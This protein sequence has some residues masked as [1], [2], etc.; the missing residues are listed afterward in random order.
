MAEMRLPGYGGEQYDCPLCGAPVTMPRSE[1]RHIDDGAV[2]AITV[3]VTDPGTAHAHIR[4][5]HPERWAQLCEQQRQ[6]NANQRIGAWP[7][8]VDGAFLQPG[9]DVGNLGSGIQ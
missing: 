6:V 7:R 8:R 1:Q 3:T 5:V 2:Q 9:E 4:D